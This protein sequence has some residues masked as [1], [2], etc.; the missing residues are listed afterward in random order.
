MALAKRFL[1]LI[2]CFCLLMPC[3]T[4]SAAESQKAENLS[5]TRYIT[6]YSGF[7]GCKF[8]FDGVVLYGKKTTGNAS[9][10]AENSDGIGSIYI[11]FQEEYGPYTVTDNDTGTTCTVGEGYFLHDFLDMQKLFGTF[12]T[13]VTVEFPNGSV[14]INEVYLY[15]PGEIPDSVQQWDMPADDQT[16]LILFSTH[17]DDEQLFFAGILPYYA[18]ELDYQVQ[19]VYLT[20]HTCDSPFRIHEMLNGLWAVGV[21]TYPVF[22]EY[23]DF[24]PDTL[25]EGYAEFESRGWTKEEMIGFVVEQI[26]RFKPLVVVAHD[27]AG[28]YGHGQ[29]MVYADLV[30]NALEITMDEAQYPASAERYG[31]WDVQKAYFHLYEENP[32]V[33]DWDQPLE[34]FDGETAFEVS[35]WRGFQ[36]HET[37]VNDF[38][39]FYRGCDTAAEVPKYNPCYYGLYRTTVGPDTV[40]S[41]FFEN[42]TSHEELDRIAE[43]ARLAEEAERQR[44]EEEEARKASEAAEKAAEEEARRQAEEQS[45]LEAEAKAFAAQ[46]KQEQTK[47]ILLIV[48]CALVILILVLIFLLIRLLRKPR[49]RKKTGKFTK[50]GSKKNN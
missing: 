11:L 34:A 6:D 31:T 25:E 26:R 45:R 13:S 18:A 19:V 27:F 17:G 15:G 22:G 42:V 23:D 50:S 16:D 38:A 37:Q 9:F 30:A 5:K 24:R 7:S 12:P 32:I 2:V 21:T 1:S 46:Q 49:K 33:M 4:V 44:Q 3:L 28:E 40:K 39:W 14:Y 43:E 35:I 8:F 20:D 41:D 29:H 47:T 10:T 36:C 48:L